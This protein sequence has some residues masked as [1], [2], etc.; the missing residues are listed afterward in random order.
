MQVLAEEITYPNHGLQGY[1]VKLER[2]IDPSKNIKKDNNHPNTSR[3]AK[4]VEKPEFAPNSERLPMGDKIYVPNYESTT[5]KLFM[6]N[7][8]MSLRGFKGDY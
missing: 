1:L 2:Q 7:F 8:D 5:S 4:L 6:F 3:V